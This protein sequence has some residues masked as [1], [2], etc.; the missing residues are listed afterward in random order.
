[1]G[2]CGLIRDPHVPSTRF[3]RPKAL[4]ETNQSHS[5]NDMGTPDESY[6][7][8]FG[9]M[10]KPAA[11]QVPSKKV[12]AFIVG[13]YSSAVHARWVSES[14]K[15]LCRAL[16]VS[17]EPY[18]FWD[19]KDASAI[20][21]KVGETLPAGAGKLLPADPSYNGPSGI[22][23]DERYL[24]PLGLD[25]TNTWV[26]DLHDLYYLSSGNLAALTKHYEPLVK[27]GLT[28]PA[29]LPQRPAS[30]A[31]T[32]RQLERLKLEVQQADPPLVITLGNEPIP[33]IFGRGTPKLATRHYG[34][35]FEG[36]VFG[37]RVLCM[38]LCHPRQA[39]QLGASS[40]AWFEAHRRWV[41]SKPRV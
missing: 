36:D 29:N 17:S 28:K 20:V 38:R 32:E 19:G 24:D 35:V 23:L 9:R 1:M 25:R 4:V 13:V 10:L 12:K 26:T 22:V 15:Q 6:R 33:Y 14:G 30:V 11:P 21:K 27:E 34:E 5:E 2:A 3:V 18:S 40:S 37:H 39:G 7:F 31:P 16:A 8:P 41:R